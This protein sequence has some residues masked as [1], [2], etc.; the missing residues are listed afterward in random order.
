MAPSKISHSFRS[1]T[2][3]ECKLVF[4]ISVVRVQPRKSRSITDLLL[5]LPSVYWNVH[6]PSKKFHG[7]LTA[8]RRDPAVKPSPNPIAA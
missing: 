7:R 1:R 3:K 5:A 4:A 2:H 6:S 8:K